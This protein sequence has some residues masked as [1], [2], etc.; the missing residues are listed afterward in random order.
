MGKDTMLLDW[1]DPNDNAASSSDYRFD[2]IL[3]T[4]RAYGIAKI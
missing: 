3:V 2:Y 4:I 1:F